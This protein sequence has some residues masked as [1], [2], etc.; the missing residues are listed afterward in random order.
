MVKVNE[1]WLGRTVD[2]LGR[3][4]DLQSEAHGVI[5]GNLAN[6][7]TPGYIPRELTFEQELQQALGQGELSL[8]RT[9]P[10]HLPPGAADVSQLKPEVRYRQDFALGNG[11]YQLDLDNE[12]AKLAQNNLKYEAT[13]RLI[14]KKLAMLREAITEGGK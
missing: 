8:Q 2:F 12:M 5:S 6:L 9:H 4:L 1:G 10:D 3:A 13:V 7:D 14:A 11:S